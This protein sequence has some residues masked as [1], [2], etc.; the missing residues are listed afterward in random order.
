[1]NKLE[2]TIWVV[3]A[4]NTWQYRKYPEMNITHRWNP[5]LGFSDETPGVWLNRSSARKAAKHMESVNQYN[6]FDVFTVKYRVRKYKQEP[7]Y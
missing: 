5:V 3:E 6:R 7:I 1:M 4:C 2:Q